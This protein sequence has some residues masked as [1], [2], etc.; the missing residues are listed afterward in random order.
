MY[1][2]KSSTKY[3]QTKFNN[4]VL[5]SYTMIKWNLSQECKY[6]LKFAYQCGISHYKMKTENHMIISVSLEKSLDKM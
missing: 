4:T 2:Q 6:S 5:G 3:L 1:I